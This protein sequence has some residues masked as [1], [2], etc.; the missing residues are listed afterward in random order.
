M[1]VNE[2]SSAWLSADVEHPAL[3][4]DAVVNVDN[5]GHDNLHF[6]FSTLTYNLNIYTW[7]IEILQS[8]ERIFNH[9]LEYKAFNVFEIILF[10]SFH[11]LAKQQTLFSYNKR[12]FS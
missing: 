10:V 8:K 3:A 12:K 9:K 1:W 7:L 5:V 11:T 2:D 6:T 4:M